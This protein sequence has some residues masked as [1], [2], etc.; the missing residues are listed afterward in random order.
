MQ[1]AEPS[2][3]FFVSL[4]IDILI[5]QARGR[6]TRSA[7]PRGSSNTPLPDCTLVKDRG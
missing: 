4:H 1:P 6:S 2:S 5:A 7:A 3:G